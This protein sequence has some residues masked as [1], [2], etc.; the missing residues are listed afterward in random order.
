MSQ[1]ILA[2]SGRK[3]SGKTTSTNFLY[4]YE[5]KKNG[6]IDFFDID[7]AGSLIVNTV[8]TNEKGEKSEGVGILDVFRHD[9]DFI[10]YA[11]QN[12]WPYVKAYNFA[13]PLKNICINLFGFSYEQCYGTDENK[14]SLTDVHKPRDVFPSDGH[15]TAREFLQ[16]FGTDVC[17]HLKD[18]I[19]TG[20]C[21]NKIKNE[22]SGFAI[23]GDCR[24][25]NEV[26]MVQNV[27][28][29]IIRLTRSLHEDS[30]KSETALDKFKSFDAVIDNQEMTIEEQNKA[31][32]ETLISWGW[33]E[34]IC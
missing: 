20:A 30:H 15:F 19:W 23:I 22:E 31:I 5:L 17:R 25:P 27:G 13:D 29:K 21:I 24:F 8:F 28:G 1:R 12:I 6:I 2:L 9:Y 33:V 11:H 10:N 32:L 18:D 4:G 3:Q 7:T 34:S 14:N 26:E 16:Y